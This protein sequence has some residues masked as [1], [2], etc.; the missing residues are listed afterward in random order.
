MPNML[1]DQCKLMSPHYHAGLPD[2]NH[3]FIYTNIYMRMGTA[4]I[5]MANES[6]GLRKYHDMLKL[7]AR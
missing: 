6:Y 4:N 5:T 1:Q 2:S 3:V 7:L